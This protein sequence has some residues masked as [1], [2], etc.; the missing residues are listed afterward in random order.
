LCPTAGQKALGGGG[1]PVTN[2]VLSGSYPGASGDWI[3]VWASTDGAN[4]NFNGT[5]YVVCATAS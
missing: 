1:S 3:V 4:H 5:A 2:F